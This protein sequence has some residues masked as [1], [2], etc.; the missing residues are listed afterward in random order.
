MTAASALL[1]LGIRR[2]T[3]LVLIAAVFALVLMM[4]GVVPL[5]SYQSQRNNL[6][7]TRARL[8]MLND[9]NA[10]LEARA[11]LLRSDVE[12][13]RVAREQFGLVKPGQSL[14][15]TPGLRTEGQSAALIDDAVSP[16]PSAT[17]SKTPS[18]GR[19][20]LD[21]LMFWR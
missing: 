17:Q 2:I 12:I 5:R 8:A 19:A 13:Q 14:V 21:T 7:A 3:F 4:L 15:L 18:R 6:E 10:R 20:I 9:R 1:R 11:T 16:V